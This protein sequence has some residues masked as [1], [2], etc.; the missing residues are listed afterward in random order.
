MSRL[1]AIYRRIRQISP[2]VFASS[3]LRF[4]RQEILIF[5][6]VNELPKQH[7]AVINRGRAIAKHLV[8]YSPTW[9]N[10][11]FPPLGGYFAENLG[12][13]RRRLR[14]SQTAASAV[15]RFSHTQYHYPFKKRML[16]APPS[17]GMIRRS[18]QPQTTTSGQTR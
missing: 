15:F 2:P 10:P 9:G 17:G 3:I 1:L 5:C 12:R 7:L 8:I 11:T 6:N 14:S 16:V 13:K 18:L 4:G